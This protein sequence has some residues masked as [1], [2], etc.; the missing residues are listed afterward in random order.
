MSVEASVTSWSLFQRGP[1]VCP[2][3]IHKPKKGVENVYGRHYPERNQLN[4]KKLKQAGIRAVCSRVG[5][6]KCLNSGVVVS[7]HTWSL[8]LSPRYF[9]LRCSVQEQACRQAEAQLK[10]CSSK[11]FIVTG[12]ILN[13]SRPDSCENRTVIWRQIYVSAPQ[14]KYV[15]AEETSN[16]RSQWTSSVSHRR[17]RVLYEHNTTVDQISKTGIQRAYLQALSLAIG[18]KVFLITFKVIDVI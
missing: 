10:D 12:L 8:A 16:A 15:R 7:S 4:E 3:K 18:P 1:T 13:L 9:V 11:R 17:P 14:Y 6:V 5:A 2:I